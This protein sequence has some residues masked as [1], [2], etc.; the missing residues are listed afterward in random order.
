MA[1]FTVILKH[2]ILDY[3]VVHNTTDTLIHKL[4]DMR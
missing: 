1:N 4:D 3:M 2:G